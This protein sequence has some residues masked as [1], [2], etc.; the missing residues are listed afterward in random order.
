MPPKNERHKI[1]NQNNSANR[2]PIT[3]EDYEKHLL[4]SIAEIQND[5]QETQLD[6]RSRFDNRPKEISRLS[7]MHQHLR[8]FQLNR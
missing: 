4:D 7:Q 3:L 8:N 1:R 5:L 6:H 2:K